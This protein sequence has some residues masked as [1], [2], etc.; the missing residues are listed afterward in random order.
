M[1]D[2]R[3][4]EQHHPGDMSA[5]SA[6]ARIDCGDGWTVWKEQ[7]GRIVAI[8]ASEYRDRGHLVEAAIERVVRLVREH[9]GETTAT[10]VFNVLTRKDVDRQDW[11]A[12]AENAPNAITQGD[13]GVPV[14]PSAPERACLELLL[15]K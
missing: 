8:C 5:A 13:G 9:R 3:L 14:I 10:E 4:E 15:P 11:W 1:H 12:W 6:T 2:G 7:F